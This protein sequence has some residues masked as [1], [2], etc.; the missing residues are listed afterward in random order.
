MD[1]RK[2][3]KLTGFFI[4][5]TI[6]IF[7]GLLIVP[8]YETSASLVGGKPIQTLY[9]PNTNHTAVLLRKHKLADINFV[10]KVDG[11]RVYLSSDYYGLP[12]HLYRETLVWDK[13][14]RIVVFELMG[15]RVFAYDAEEKREIGKNE[16]SKY[17]LS[18]VV[19]DNNFYASIRDIDEK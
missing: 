1:F 18:P 2:T 3:A 16:L 19:S 4:C 12:D 8:F 10:V 7:I 15:K 17:E 14:G 13:T 6:G 5:L 11:Q 9:A